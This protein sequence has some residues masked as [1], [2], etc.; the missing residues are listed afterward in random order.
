MRNPYTAPQSLPQPGVGLPGAPGAYSVELVCQTYSYLVHRI[1]VH[2][3]FS[4]FDQDKCL[5]Y[6][7]VYF[8]VFFK[9]LS[10]CISWG[11]WWSKHGKHT[12]SLQKHLLFLKNVAKIST[13]C[14]F[15]LI[16][17][18]LFSLFLQPSLGFIKYS[19]PQPPGRQS[20][21]VV[22]VVVFSPFCTIGT[23]TL[24]AE[25]CLIQ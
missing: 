10:T 16:F 3:Y 11:Y 23:T 20:V 24:A 2:W 17:L 8:W 14:Y 22:S 12:H 19:I 1:S 6:I 21:E 5:W 18:F 7:Y 9:D 25:V 15:P 4:C 13:A